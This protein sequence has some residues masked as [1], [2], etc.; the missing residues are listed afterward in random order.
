MWRAAG[1]FPIRY[2]RTVVAG[3]R[4]A[5]HLR[6]TAAA[7]T[8]P[9]VFTS[10]SSTE[11]TRPRLRPYW[12]SS[13]VSDAPAATPAIRASEARRAERGEDQQIAADLHERRLGRGVEQR[14]QVPERN[15]TDG[16]GDRSRGEDH[17]DPGNGPGHHGDVGGG[18]TD[19]EGVAAAGPAAGEETDGGD[20]RRDRHDGRH[21]D[22]SP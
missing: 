11:L 13:T 18:R 21:D 7:R 3:A 1:G 10:T 17:P 14:R 8:A 2:R 5:H 20:G 4:P 9:A 15:E 19:R 22:V 6:V 12:R 16:A